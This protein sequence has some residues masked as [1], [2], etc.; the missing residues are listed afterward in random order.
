MPRNHSLIQIGFT[1]PELVE[2]R[3][4]LRLIIQEDED[5]VVNV[6]AESRAAKASALQKLI[7]RLPER[8]AVPETSVSVFDLVYKRDP[9]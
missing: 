9:Q 7:A 1:V 8:P 4:A 6:D 5:C 2:L 3:R